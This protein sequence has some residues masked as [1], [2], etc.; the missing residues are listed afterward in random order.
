MENGCCVT[1]FVSLCDHS[2]ITFALTFSRY[3]GCFARCVKAGKH[4]I[5]RTSNTNIRTLRFCVRFNYA[6]FYLRFSR[7]LDH[8]FRSFP[9]A[10]SIYFSRLEN[11]G[12]LH[13]VFVFQTLYL[14]PFLASVSRLQGLFDSFH[15]HFKNYLLSNNKTFGFRPGTSIPILY[16][17]SHQDRT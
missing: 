12:A 3:P 7:C 2:H 1:A 14:L 10:V 8:C 9:F 4:V 16:L 5:E 15:K 13:G 17:F 11:T 6:S